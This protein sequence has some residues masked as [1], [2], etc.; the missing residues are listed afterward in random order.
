M[1]KP[2]V[3][4]YTEAMQ[5][6]DGYVYLAKTGPEYIELIEFAMLE[7]SA[8]LQQKREAFAK[9]HTWEANADEIY[10]VMEK[11]MIQENLDK[12][13]RHVNKTKD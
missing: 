12:T 8:S 4:T 6:F 2:V 9:G 7:N 5:V 10:R 13:E 3:A 11:V 1:G